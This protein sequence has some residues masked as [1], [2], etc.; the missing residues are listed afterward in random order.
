M[1]KNKDLEDT[2]IQMGKYMKANGQMESKEEKV[3]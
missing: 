2:N 3:D 1:E